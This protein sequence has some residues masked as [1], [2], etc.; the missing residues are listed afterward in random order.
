MKLLDKAESKGEGIWKSPLALGS[1]LTDLFDG[2]A[3]VVFV[4]SPW[5]V[6]GINGGATGGSLVSITR[7]GPFQAGMRVLA[8]RIWG[9]RADDAVWSRRACGSTEAAAVVPSKEAQESSDTNNNSRPG[10]RWMGAEVLAG[11]RL[12]RRGFDE[13]SRSTRGGM[14]GSW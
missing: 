4:A 10:W 9:R 2:G 12:G 8:S 13:A 6:G 5:Y 3:D 1:V 7:E 11:G 14:G